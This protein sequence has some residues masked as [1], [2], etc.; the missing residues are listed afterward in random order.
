MSAIAINAADLTAPASAFVAVS[1]TQIT[2]SASAQTTGKDFSSL[3]KKEESVQIQTK[4]VEAKGSDNTVKSVKETSEQKT[5]GKKVTADANKTDPTEGTV[6]AAGTQEQETA[7]PVAEETGN[8]G[9]VTIKAS[10]RVSVTAVGINMKAPAVDE[11]TTEDLIDRCVDAMEAISTLLQRFAQILE[12]TVDKLEGSYEELDFSFEDI[13][14]TQK[15]PMLMLNLGKCDDISQ[16]LCEGAP[17]QIYQDLKEAIGDMFETVQQTAQELTGLVVQDMFLD[18]AAEL[19]ILPKGF[20]KLITGNEEPAQEIAAPEAE[21]PTQDA[22]TFTVT[23]ETADTA[24]DQKG[25]ENTDLGFEIR[26]ERDQDASKTK[27]TTTNDGFEDFVKGLE[28]AV[29]VT[30]T[31]EIPMIN[32]QPDIREIVMRVVDAIKVNLSPDKTS[33]ELS[34]S[35][36]SLGKISL[37]ITSKEGTLTA[38]IATENEVTKQAIESQLEVL[39][40]TIAQ[41]GIRVEAIEVS[42][43]GFSF[44][45]SNNA[46]KG[47]SENEEKKT[48]AAGRKQVRDGEAGISAQETAAEAQPVPEGSTVNFVA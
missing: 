19:E 2:V 13:I 44:A 39:K 48:S 20:V 40:E 6:D 25:S 9:K 24:N 35:P 15:L 31:K 18:K 30:D 1:K 27:K 36:Q 42:I 16:V 37:Q 28:N 32:G 23:R 47:E 46:Q 33:I 7:L 41:Q 12:I 45:D 34:L 11:E 10:V 29:R 14:D 4:P 3:F 26:T 43:A 5:D 17:S 38:R 21:A 8:E 22:P